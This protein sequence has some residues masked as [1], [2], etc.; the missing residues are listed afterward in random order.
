MYLWLLSEAWSKKPFKFPGPPSPVMGGAGVLTGAI[1][2]TALKS[3]ID[4][5]FDTDK[6]GHI[7][8]IIY[9]LG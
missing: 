6:S 5:F 3:S 9:R 4:M 2:L 8:P 1:M 7:T